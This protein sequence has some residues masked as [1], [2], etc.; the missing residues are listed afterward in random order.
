MIRLQLELTNFKAKWADILR[1]LISGVENNN[2]KT[3][4]Q[5][6]FKILHSSL[7]ARIDPATGVKKNQN[8]KIRGNN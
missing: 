5:H 1:I 7:L 4:F 2:E 6:R 8:P 3:L